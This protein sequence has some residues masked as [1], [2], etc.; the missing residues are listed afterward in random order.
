MGSEMCIRDRISS[1]WPPR[2]RFGGSKTKSDAGPLDLLT[3]VRKSPKWGV[4]KIGEFEDFE[5]KY[6]DSGVPWDSWERQIVAW[7]HGFVA[8]HPPS[9]ASWEQGGHHSTDPRTAE[10]APLVISG[11]ALWR[12]D[13]AK[14]R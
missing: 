13:R 7:L 4:P 5:A 9:K 3:S 6:E 10:I 1:E 14:L 8:P 2:G 11:L 12:N